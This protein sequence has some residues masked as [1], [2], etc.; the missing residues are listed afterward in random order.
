MM[1]T[2]A[3]ARWTGQV[4]RA[5]AWYAPVLAR[6]FDDAGVRAADLQMLEVVSAQFGTR[7]RFLTELALD[8]PQAGGDLAGDPLLDEDF[9]ILS[10]VHSAKG[11]E[12][13][14]VYLINVADGNFPNE[15]ATG[16][17]AAIEEERRLLYVAMT[18]ARDA[19]ALIEPQR[20]YVTHQAK[21]GG[22]YVHGARSR[23]LTASVLARLEQCGSQDGPTAGD[24]ALGAIEP[25]GEPPVDV[26]KRLRGMW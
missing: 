20:Y 11:Q 21:F 19:L 1:A 3:D 25:A 7:E 10:T 23:F 26:K 14:A 22:D 13:D 12:W 15:Y 2:S 16:D 4:A 5:R 6:R 24:P 18:R 9:L 17:A 8:P